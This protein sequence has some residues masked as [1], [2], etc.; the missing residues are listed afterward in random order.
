MSGGGPEDVQVPCMVPLEGPKWTS[1]LVLFGRTSSVSFGTSTRRPLNVSFGRPQVRYGNI[2]WAYWEGGGGSEFLNN[3]IKKHP[4]H[5]YS[6]LN[7]LSRNLRIIRLIII[8]L[9]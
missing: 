6:F 3:S 8:T 4:A 5:V 2:Q 1:I 7:C 9:L